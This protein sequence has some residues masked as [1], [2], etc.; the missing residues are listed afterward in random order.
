MPEPAKPFPI[1]P[2]SGTEPRPEDG[3]QEFDLAD[4]DGQARQV[5]ELIERGDR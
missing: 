1:E 2:A 5:D 3:P 4:P